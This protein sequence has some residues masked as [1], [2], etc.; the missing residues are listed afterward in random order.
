MGSR[1]LSWVGPGDSCAH[2]RSGKLK[3]S[4]VKINLVCPR[5]TEKPSVAGAP[6]IVKEVMFKKVA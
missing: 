3:D 4:E 6:W 5:D 1:S 2:R